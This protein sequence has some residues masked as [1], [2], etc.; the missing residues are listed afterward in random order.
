MRDIPAETWWIHEAGYHHSPGD[1]GFISATDDNLKRAAIDAGKSIDRQGCFGISRSDLKT[2]ALDVKHGRL[3]TV[4]VWF[5]PG[6]R[7]P[8]IALTDP[9]CRQSD[10]AVTIPS[11]AFYERGTCS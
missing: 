3:W 11:R 2:N 6:T 8:T 5:E 1:G 9:W 10:H 7:R 4:H